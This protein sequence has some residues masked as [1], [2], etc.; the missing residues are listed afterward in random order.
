MHILSQDTLLG[1]VAKVNS[2][3]IYMSI[4]RWSEGGHFSRSSQLAIER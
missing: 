1:T 2:V 3:C 4:E